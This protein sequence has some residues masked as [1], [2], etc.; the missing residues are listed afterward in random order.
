M[1]P[2]QYKE[3]M[4]NIERFEDMFRIVQDGNGLF[5]I[6]QY[7]EMSKGVYGWDSNYVLNSSEPKRFV[8]KFNA[9]RHLRKT[10][11]SLKWSMREGF[12]LSR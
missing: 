11:R 4:M 7:K 1:S 5:L 6:Q 2:K 10:I 12:V 9:E 3:K 8:F